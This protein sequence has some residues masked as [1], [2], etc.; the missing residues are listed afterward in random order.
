MA[1]STKEIKSASVPMPTR[2]F[3]SFPK[4]LKGNV[5]I[6]PFCEVGQ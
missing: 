3:G 5:S 6:F 4:L 1:L 2:R